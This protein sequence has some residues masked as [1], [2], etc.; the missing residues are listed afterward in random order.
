MKET[1]IILRVTGAGSRG[2]TRGDMAVPLG[3]AADISI[4]VDSIDT[5]DIQ[6]VARNR[7]VV[8]IAPSIPMTLIQP[9][10][11]PHT[12]DDAAATQPAGAG[13][14]GGGHAVGSDTSPCTGDG[15]V[16]AVLDTGIDSA[17]K[18]FEGVTLVRQNFT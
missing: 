3:G 15:I 9:V 18:A 17:H 12:A 11:I 13:V 8:C 4:E 2:A 10:P 14:A 5:S 1:Q 6:K 7:D 16:V